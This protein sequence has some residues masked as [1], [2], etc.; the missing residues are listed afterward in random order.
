MRDFHVYLFVTNTGYY[1]HSGYWP[2]AETQLSKDVTEKFCNRQMVKFG[3]HP[4]PENVNIFL[5]I[6]YK[7]F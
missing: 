7:L 1:K 5:T 6:S 3:R 2:V 4:L